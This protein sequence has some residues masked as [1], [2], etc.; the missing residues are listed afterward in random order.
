MIYELKV[1]ND[2]DCLEDENFIPEEK[3]YVNTKNI[4]S[5]YKHVMFPEDEELVVSGLNINGVFLPLL[6]DTVNCDEGND[7]IDKV[8]NEIVSIMKQENTT[9]GEG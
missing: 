5:I 9:A 3:F 8:F 4:V 6:Q 7:Y 1:Q 2:I